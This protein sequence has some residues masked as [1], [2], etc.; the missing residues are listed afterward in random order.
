MIFLSGYKIQQPIFLGSK[1]A[2]YTGQR[3]K[4]GRPV[5]VKVA[6]NTTAGDKDLLKFSHERDLLN[7]LRIPG[8]PLCYGVERYRSSCALILESLPGKCVAGRDGLQDLPL[9]DVL[10]IG[11][12]MAGIL[13]ALHGNN[14]VHGDI[15]PEAIF[16]DPESEAVWLGDFD[17]ASFPDHLTLGL[18]QPR[19]ATGTLP[20]M[21]PE[22]TGRLNRS[23]DFRTDF[24]SLGATLYELMT[25]SPPFT[26]ADPLEIVHS[27]L[28]RLPLA[29]CAANHRIPDMASAIVM[30]L[31]AKS[32]ED[33]YQSAWG[34]QHDFDEC[35]RQ[36]EAKARITYFPLGSQDVSD[37][38][39]VS[40]KLYGRKQEKELLLKYFEGIG[41]DAARM[42]M[43]SGYSGI[44]KT[45]LVQ[46]IYKPLIARTGYY[47]RGKFDRLHGAIPYSG[48][49]QAFQDLVD[50]LLS[51]SEARL[52]RWKERLVSCL[53]PNIRAIIDV[54][55]EMER[56]TGP[57]AP[58]IELGANEAQN[59]FNRVFLEFMRIFCQAEHPLVI[60][61]DDLQW[62]DRATLKLIELIMGTGELHHLL[63]I[64]AYRK[65]EVDDAHPLMTTLDTVVKNGGILR[66]IDVSPLSHD[67][68]THMI[69]DMLHKGHDE[70]KALA[71]LITAK[72]GGNPFFVSHFL[73][74]L[75]QESLLTFEAASR[76]WTWDFD[77]IKQLDITDN[78]IDLL[79]HRFHQ[80]SAEARAVLQMA[81]CIG[82]RFDLRML[83][84]ITGTSTAA[85]RRDLIPAL[86]QELLIPI[87]VARIR[88]GMAQDNEEAEVY[89][90]QHD[91]VQQA[92]YTLIPSSQRKLIHIRIGRALL[93][94]FDE[95]AR[96]EQIF[97]IL[98]HLNF[99][100]ELITMPEERL[101]LAG[102]NLLAGKKAKS[103]VAFE[104]ALNYIKTGMALL[105]ADGWSSCYDLTLRLHL[106]CLE[107]LRLTGGM[108]QMTPLFEAVKKNCRAPLDAVGAYESRIKGFMAQDRLREALV[109]A[110]EILNL[111][112]VGM[113]DRARKSESRRV[114]KE[115]MAALDG[116][117]IETLVDLPE[118]KD[119]FQL[120]VM[121]ILV[122]MISV[123]YIGT[124]DLFSHLLCKQVQGAIRYGNAP[125]SVFLYAAF[126]AL[127]CRLGDDIQAGY[128]F[129]AVALSLAEK[130][131]TLEHKGQA[132]HAVS[133]YIKHWKAP[134][135]ETLPLAL[136]GYQSALDVGDFEFASYNVYC[137]CMHALLC[138][139]PLETVE[140]EM[141]D[142]HPIIQKLK[143]E[144][145]LRYLKTF[146]QTTLNLLGRSQDPCRFSDDDENLLMLYKQANNRLGIFYLYFCKLLLHYLFD[147]HEEAIQYAELAEREDVGEYA[148]PLE[149]PLIVFYGALARLACCRK[150]PAAQ[151]E[152]LL[153][154][155]AAGRKKLSA[156]ARQAPD[157]YRPK[158]H[159]VEAE[160]LSILGDDDQ[161]IEHYQRAIET[162]RAQQFI[163]D[164]GLANELAAGY[165]QRKNLSAF[166]GPFLRRAHACYTLWGG[167]AKALHME[168]KLAELPGNHTI[169][170]EPWQHRKESPSAPS[171]GLFAAELDMATVMKASQAIYGEIDLEKLLAA[172]MHFVI[173]NSGAERGSLV[174]CAEGD[175]AIAAQHEAG[176]GKV[177]LLAE[178]PIEKAKDVS[179]AIVH[180]V[181][182]TR[183]FLV[184]DDVSQD[185][186][187]K[188]DPYVLRL[189]PRAL[190]CCPIIHK[191]RLVGIL[192]LESRLIPGLFSSI[193]VELIRM[194]T[195]QMAVS[196]DNAS[197]YGRLKKAEEKYR[198]IFEN[199]VE[200]IYQ[201]TIGGQIVSANPAMARILGY[202]SPEDLT[203]HVT[204]IGRQLYVSP[205]ARE[206]FLNVIRKEKSL[207]GFEV[208][209]LRK[210]KSIIWV[211]LH[212]RLLEDR[213]GKN[214]NI[215]GIFSDITNRKKVT[216]ALRE[217]E[218]CLR[219][220]NIRLRAN[221]KDRYRFRDIIGKS[222][223]MQDIYE[224]ILKA[225]ATEANVMIGGESGTGKELVARA[226]HDLSDRKDQNIVTVNC[227][228]IPENLM[229]SEFFGYK[230][231]AFTGA[232]RDK[233]GYLD[234]ADGGTL[235]LDELGE[236]SLN[237]QVKLL[238]VLDRR[239]YIPVGGH[240]VRHADIRFIAATNRDLQARV[241]Q[242]LMRED[243]FYR[244][245]ILPAQLPPLRERKEDLPLLVEHFMGEFG[246]DAKLPPLTGK[247]MEAIQRHDWPGNVRELQ[248]VLRRY[249][250]LGHFTLE[251]S[252]EGGA[253][254][255][256][257]MEK[258]ASRPAAKDHK[259]SVESYE[260]DLIEASLVKNQWHREK[261][262]ASLGMARRTFFRK[263]KKFGFDKHP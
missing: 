94:N 192:Y 98:I 60:F 162:A 224:F 160:R 191:Q 89:R 7:H 188:N 139:K 107:T 1:N 146:H 140:K 181:A 229:E 195:S 161:A 57:Q 92:A 121:K 251:I 253:F 74:T 201:T 90:F 175:L 46:E 169:D 263:M 20:Y 99:A 241:R 30:K 245:H 55:P 141:E 235:F 126:G 239:G 228:A 178:V 205:E 119:P 59:R 227:G 97:D 95:A 112:G 37:R 105:P 218:A 199:A 113:P 4:D 202:D 76:S 51:E 11:A 127:L 208:Q 102:L 143:Q 147:R 174:L 233:Q 223:A 34:L 238:R 135:R 91:R 189:K 128:R 216:E 109:T 43:V 155:V 58:L 215:E 197:L 163:Q 167:H 124:P 173:E 179:P 45:S 31:L 2:Y 108:E 148:G 152:R 231:G 96:D 261:A 164:E 40:R 211:S 15:K 120:A 156:W 87:K 48:F 165:W 154:K 196:I 71:E 32:P 258:H 56:V 200:G 142:Y 220:E 88:E 110:R 158:F 72:T 244:I 41:D 183:E 149:V 250:T 116:K 207:S 176:P 111:L 17:S 260:K 159:L 257:P 29:P 184:L 242:G 131:Y 204:D 122:S 61:L 145:S 133:C 106:E 226:I 194:L 13:S 222:P 77:K 117:E 125:G 73:T 168:K 180:Y 130:R 28:A 9:R 39:N 137:Y 79:I 172:L 86:Q 25:G 6:A 256:L 252:P 193:R 93:E 14:V 166:A 50:Q 138:G 232:N 83:C 82:S 217:S 49:V 26:G 247:M 150:A 68:V 255:D 81:A 47:I 69:A 134:L 213:E 114:L 132:I 24:Y 203:S 209:F 206:H 35:L 182:R 177:S 103:S 186:L 66:Y 249:V 42:V 16:Y 70:A 100:A 221:I 254:V 246:K 153:K 36:L 187:F 67:S 157:N 64:G 243:F 171:G 170:I 54:I 259:S 101:N 118:M 151:R 136:S 210:N 53:G 212:A 52:R 23:V 123:I 3:K 19:M 75:H 38:L 234:L 5:T 80:L 248:N 78:V 85:V 262:A 10:T 104:P 236:L 18:P 230:K 115:T 190:C 84:R 185:D 225:A 27:H 214:F 65:N 62:V 22:Q 8:I 219:K 12:K 144:T 33:R 63:L 44:G 240:D 237:M 21:S 198:R 129:G